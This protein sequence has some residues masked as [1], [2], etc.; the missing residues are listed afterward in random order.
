MT[1]QPQPTRKSAPPTP[2]DINRQQGF[3]AAQDESYE[4]AH[5]VVPTKPAAPVTPPSTTVV[6]A[7]S[8][9]LTPFNQEA[10]ERNLTKWGSGGLPPLTHNGLEGGFRTTGGEEV[11][12]SETI[13]AAHLDETLKEWIHFNGEGVPPTI[14][15]VGIYEDRELP[16]RAELGETDEARWE[17]DRFRGEPTDP[18]RTSSVRQSCRPTRAAKSMN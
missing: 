1:T 2:A 3:S 9:A 10:F 7:S 15:S 12:V 11:D 4:A 13:F 18:G 5:A 17:K 16:P 8:T 6:A 14:I